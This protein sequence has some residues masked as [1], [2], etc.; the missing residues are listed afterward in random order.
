MALFT[1]N[2]SLTDRF[3]AY[4]NKTRK[5]IKDAKH[6]KDQ[7][8]KEESGVQSRTTFNIYAALNH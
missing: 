3:E 6:Y 5:S 7:G 2:R 1:L 4:D 8:M